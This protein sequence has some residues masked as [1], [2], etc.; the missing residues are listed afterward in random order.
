VQHPEVTTI[1][2]TERALQGF[3]EPIG[4]EGRNVRA[5]T[6][7]H[8]GGTVPIML[9]P[10]TMRHRATA[11]AGLAAGT[12]PSATSRSDR[13][14]DLSGVVAHLIRAMIIIN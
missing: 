14:G 5:R 2:G 4:P 9:R 1:R 12:C 10:P 13:K 7:R 8:M 6:Q 3:G 11:R